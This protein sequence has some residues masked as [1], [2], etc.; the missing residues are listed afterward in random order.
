[1]Q[2]EKITRYRLALAQTIDMPTP[3]P[4]PTPV[5]LSPDYRIEDYACNE[6]YPDVAKPEGVALNVAARVFPEGWVSPQ[7][8]AAWGF[9]AYIETFDW[10]E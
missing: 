8:G 9:D 5:P 1:M 4:T 2:S 10:L 6:E 3:V 7:G